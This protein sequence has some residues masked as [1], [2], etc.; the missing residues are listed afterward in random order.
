M[1]NKKSWIQQIKFDAN[2][3]VPAIVQDAQ[4]GELLMVAYMN[5]QAVAK[6]L[7]TGKTHFYSRSRKKMWLKG[8]S[9]GHIQKVKGIYL[10]CDGDAILVKARQIDGACH[11]GYKNCFFRRLKNSRWKIIGTKVFDP[12]AV[13][14]TGA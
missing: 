7:R 13:Y 5:R 1:N 9:S 14:R 2:R 12:E 4:T 10:D 11:T 8:E 3:L 6:T